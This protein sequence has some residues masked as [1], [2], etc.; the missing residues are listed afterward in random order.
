MRIG[1]LKIGV[2]LGITFS[3]VTLITAILGFSSLRALT[4]VAAKWRTFSDV[5]IKKK[6]VQV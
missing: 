3:L 5:S 2:R 1:D 4:D 6:D